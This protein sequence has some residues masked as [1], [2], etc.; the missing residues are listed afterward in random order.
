MLSE[1]RQLGRVST[2]GDGA[3]DVR[4]SIPQHVAYGLH[5]LQFVATTRTGQ[6]VGVAVGLW[7]TKDTQPFTDVSLAT[8]HGAAIATLAVYDH[9]AGFTDDRYRP[10]M[11]VSDTQAITMMSALFG[12]Q[13]A[14]VLTT[15]GGRLR[16]GDAAKLIAQ[17]FTQPSGQDSDPFYDVT[18]P[19]Q[20]AALSVLHAHGLVAGFTN[21][22]FRPTERITRAQFASLI[23][24]AQ[25]QLARM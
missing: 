20:Q 21:G 23:V 25:A 9:V 22:S 6:P 16:R 8:T 19:D 18:D 13:F 11:A 2:N 1:P 17:L 4:I 3:A 15:Q 7:V 14:G 5:T 24:H 10:N 12:E